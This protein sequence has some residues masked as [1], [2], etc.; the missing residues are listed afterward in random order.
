M[1][2]SVAK[3]QKLTFFSKNRGRRG[4]YGLWKNCQMVHDDNR[5]QTVRWSFKSFM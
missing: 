3:V 2:W 4:N 5:F 1:G